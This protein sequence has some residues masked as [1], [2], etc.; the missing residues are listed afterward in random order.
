MVGNDII[1]Y[2]D[3]W[4]VRNVKFMIRLILI[5]EGLC[6]LVI[7]GSCCKGGSKINSGGYFES[8]YGC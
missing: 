7:I 6:I 1:I 8:F 4:I 2:I 5:K 3:Y